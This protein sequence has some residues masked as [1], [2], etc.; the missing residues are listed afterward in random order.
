MDPPVTEIQTVRGKLCLNMIVKNE[1]KIIERLLASVLSI[2]D[3]YCICDTGS[4]DDTVQRIET[5]MRTAGKPGIILREPFRNFGYNR[6]FALT[7]AAPWGEY[8]L[9][10]DADMCLEIDPA[11][12]PADLTADEYSII[13]YNS[14][15]EYYNTRIVRTGVGIT[16]VGPT[17]E[18]YSVPGGLQRAKLSTLRIRDI[19]DGGAKADKFE[20]DIRLLQAGL[21]EEPDNPRYHFYLANSYRDLGRHTE[22]IAAYRRRVELGGW[23]EEVFQACL[24]I[25][26]CYRHL[27]DKANAVYWWLEGYGRHPKRAETLYEVTKMY[28]EE[29]K[30]QL[31]MT[32]CKLGAAIPYPKDDV[33]FIDKAVYSHLFDYEYSVLAFY[34]GAP[35]DHRRYLHLL[36]TGYNTGNVLSNYQFYARRLADLAG[37]RIVDFSEGGVVKTV[38]GRTDTFTSSSPCIIPDPSKPGSYLMNVRYVN[39][40]IGGDGTYHFTN[41]D[42]KIVTINKVVALDRDL[43]IQ[44]TPIWLDAVRDPHLRYQGVEDVKLYDDGSGTVR[45][46]GTV[47]DPATLQLTVGGGVYDTTQPMLVPTAMPSPTGRECEKNWCYFPDGRL[48]YE[49]SPLTI[50][51]SATM[52]TVVTK[53]DAVPPVFRL[54]R[55]SSNGCRVC[56][57]ETWFLCHVVDYSSPRRYYH[58]LVVLDTATGAVR[59]HSTLFKFH[60][61]PIEYAL[62][63]VVEADRI[64]VSY[65]R[66]DRTSAVAVIPRDVVERA[67]L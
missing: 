65:S 7:A 42:G 52:S 54:V 3:T 19:G 4:T 44:G 34:T 41:N 50:Y 29:G 35:I 18:Y 8:A 22:A 51:D 14:A 58:L 32:F 1:S 39:Y 15:M 27:G 17:H 40:R 31:G 59:R 66:W 25:G 2:V 38:A 56:D 13:Q 47:Q 55:G 23:V 57:D 62:G 11:F 60:G 9:L 48:V 43:Q 46:L 36:G 53:T 67:L 12:S 10:L 6:S 30:H 61:D 28:R 64:L 37:V 16:C 33:L 49:W 5:F 63:L 45:F 20:R 26:R 24:E 21:V